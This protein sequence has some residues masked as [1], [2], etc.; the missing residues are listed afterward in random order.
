MKL[1][2]LLVFL[3]ALVV[4]IGALPAFADETGRFEDKPYHV[5]LGVGSAFTCG[6]RMRIL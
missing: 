4:L 2:K 3:L 6:Y 5:S 1:K